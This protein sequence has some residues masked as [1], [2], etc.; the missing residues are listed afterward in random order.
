MPPFVACILLRET[1]FLFNVSI[2][3]PMARCPSTT[4]HSYGILIPVVAHYGLP[5]PLGH[6]FTNFFLHRCRYTASARVWTCGE[7]SLATC[8]ACKHGARRLN[9]KEQEYGRPDWSERYA[10]WILHQAGWLSRW[11]RCRQRG[12]GYVEGNGGGEGEG[13]TPWT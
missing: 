12:H 13:F 11:M 4:A 5:E 2:L 8:G 6:V 7:R 10:A 3:N 9:E 1:R